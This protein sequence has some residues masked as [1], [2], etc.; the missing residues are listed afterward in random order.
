MSVYVES[1]IL[2]LMA[3][4]GPRDLDADARRRI[5]QEFTNTRSL[6]EKWS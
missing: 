1:N 3:A 5:R 2:L 6:V 4:L